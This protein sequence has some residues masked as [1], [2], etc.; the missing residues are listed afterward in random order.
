MIEIRDIKERDAAAL[1]DLN[2]TL[3]RETTFLMWEPGERTT[4]VEEYAK[5]IRSVVERDNQNIFVAEDGGRLVGY[6]RAVGWTARRGS[7]RVHVV[8]AIRRSHWGQGIGTRLFEELD[9]WA[10]ERDMR[11][12]ELTVMVHNEAAVALYEK[13]GFTIEGT[14]K[15]S[16]FVDGSFVDEYYMAKLL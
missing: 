7:R 4:S 10:R 15:D 16:V 12:L 2:E 8:I 13:M 9:R 3:D 11:R 14:K 1:H 6:L 5:Q